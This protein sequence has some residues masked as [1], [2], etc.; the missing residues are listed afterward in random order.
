[1]K[2]TTLAAIVMASTVTLAYSAGPLYNLMNPVDP[3]DMPTPGPTFEVVYNVDELTAPS[4]SAI[5]MAVERSIAPIPSPTKVKVQVQQ[6][7]E[8]EPEAS[9]PEWIEIKPNPEDPTNAQGRYVGPT[10]SPGH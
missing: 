6:N 4:P 8:P 9:N 7:E 1:M 5:Q 10:R 3:F 2:K